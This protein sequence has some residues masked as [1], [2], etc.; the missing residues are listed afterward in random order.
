MIPTTTQ[1]QKIINNSST[2]TATIFT[3]MTETAAEPQ[4]LKNVHRN[5]IDA[6]NGRISIT[7][8]KGH[9]NGIYQLQPKTAEMLR[10]YLNKH[11]EQYPLP[12][13]KCLE[14]AWYKYRKITAKKL[15]EPDLMKVQLKNLRNY[16]GARFYYGKG[17]KDTIATQRFMRHKKLDTTQHYLQAIIIQDNDEEYTTVA[18]Q[19]GT[20]QTQKDILA[21]ANAGYQ[22]VTEADGYQYFRKRKGTSIY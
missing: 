7:G 19:L 12:E 4:E 17:A 22:K 1:V 11:P 6:Q 3:I 8:T 5:Q 9:A 18:I 2:N 10:Q 16:A 15:C 20:P 21:Y 13:P 14:E